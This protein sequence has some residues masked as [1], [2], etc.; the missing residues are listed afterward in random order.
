MSIAAYNDAA[1]TL[2]HGDGRVALAGMA[3]RSV[4]LVITDPPYDERTHTMAR[5]TGGDVPAGG[6]ALSGGKARFVSW[7]L[8]DQYEVFTEFGRI[9]RRWVIAS[10]PFSVAAAFDEDPPEGLRCLRVGAWI[11]T[12]P[13]PIFSADRPAMGWETFVCLH[14]DDAKPAW[15]N[16][17]RALN[18]VGPT[19]QGT[20]HP[21]AKPLPMIRS[22]VTAFSHPGDLILD[23][24]VG[25]GTTLIAARAENRQA[26]GYEDDADSV[27]IAVGRLGGVP[28]TLPKDDQDNLFSIGATA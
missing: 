7:T 17:G 13:M 23:P 10:V 11:K 16:G 8:Q 22:W 3:D 27:R 9:A 14:R 12:Q 18:Y 25:S 24:F 19:A 5:S 4:D 28:T 2:H 15:N 26:I 21:T 1:V 6:R 20:G